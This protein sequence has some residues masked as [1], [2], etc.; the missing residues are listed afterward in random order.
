MTGILYGNVEY[1]HCRIM[2]SSY[3]HVSPPTSLARF[4]DLI[5]IVSATH[6]QVPKHIEVRE[7]PYTTAKQM[8]ERMVLGMHRQKTTKCRKTGRADWTT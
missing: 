5:R 7:W 6:S 3:L 4:W 2:Q 1:R 8:A